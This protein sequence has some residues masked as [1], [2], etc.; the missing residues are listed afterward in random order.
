MNIIEDSNATFTRDIDCYLG[1]AGMPM[2]DPIMAKI[3]MFI[4]ILLYCRHIYDVF[5]T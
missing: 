4:P 2:I 3:L 5:G 1:N